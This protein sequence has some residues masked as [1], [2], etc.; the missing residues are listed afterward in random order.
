MA[1]F[2]MVT[3]NSVKFIL[4]RIMQ[5]NRIQILSKGR[6]EKL[7]IFFGFKK[8]TSPKSII[9]STPWYEKEPAEIVYNSDYL[10]GETIS[11]SRGHAHSAVLMH[12][13]YIPL[14]PND[15]F[16]LKRVGN[17]EIGVEIHWLTA[18]L[19][20]Q[21]SRPSPQCFINGNTDLLEKIATGTRRLNYKQ[22]ETDGIRKYGKGKYSV[23]VLVP[24]IIITNFKNG[25]LIIHNTLTNTFEATVNYCEYEGPKTSWPTDRKS[26]V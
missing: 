13:L 18:W 11:T 17:L 12:K 3:I 16:V 19:E 22:L 7:K 1:G 15:F 25:D 23:G 5:T 14:I 2:C 10:K 9:S 26:V 4:C 21:R 6:I 24:S 20:I 8:K